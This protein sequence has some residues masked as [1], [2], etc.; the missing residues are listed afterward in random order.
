MQAIQDVELQCKFAERGC[1]YVGARSIVMEHM[2]DCSFDLKV[3][4]QYLTCREMVSMENMVDHLKAAHQ[5]REI[6]ATNGKVS[7]K[8]KK[9]HINGQWS[10]WIVFLEGHIFFLHALTNEDYWMLW[11]V[12]MG[13]KKDAQKFEVAMS[14]IDDQGFPLMTFTGSAKVFGAEEK[15]K[16]VIDV[17]KEEGVV[18][19]RKEIAENVALKR[20]DGSLDLKVCYDIKRK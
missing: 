10:Q 6:L 4:C 19:L 18:Q 12:L 9:C 13:T 16:N 15:M 8:W 5:S 17:M 14:I 2:T 20:A 3:E 1:K 11:V 7:I